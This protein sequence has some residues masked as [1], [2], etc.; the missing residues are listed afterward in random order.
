MKGPFLC[1]LGVFL[2]SAFLGVPSLCAQGAPSP[3]QPAP[4]AVS[5]AA[6]PKQSATPPVDLSPLAQGQQLYRVGKFEAASEQYN[7]II[8]QGVDAGPAYAGLARV[9]LKQRKIGEAHAAAQKAV[10]L[11]PQLPTAHVALAE[12]YFRQGRFP[13]TEHELLPL[14]QSKSPDPRAL[15]LLS[16]VYRA[17]SYYARAKMLVDNAHSLDPADPDIRRQWMATL[18]PQ[19]RLK[20]LEAYLSGKTNDNEKE[21]E[22]L[23]REI[24]DLKDLIGQPSRGCHLTTKIASTQSKLEGLMRDEKHLRGYGLKVVVNGVTSKLLLDTGAGGILITKQIA[25]KAGV[26]RVVETEFGGIGNEKAAAGY[27]G[28]ADSIKIGELEFQNCY[29]DVVEKS[30]RAGGDGLIGADVF[31]DFLI[32]LNLVD[33]KFSLSPLPPLPGEQ[34]K[35]ATLES[36]GSEDSRF[37]DRHIAPEMKSYT[38]V[39]RFGHDLLIQTHLNEGPPKLF[40]IDTGAFDN[41]ISP[42]AARE[43]TKVHS[44]ASFRISGINGEVKN[45]M[46]AD[47]V[48]LQFAHLKQT[49]HDIFSID[50]SDISDSAGTEVSGILGFAMLYL[51]DI[52]IDYRDGLVDMSFDPKRWQ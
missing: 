4:P 5:P 11:A 30:S 47:D 39:Y 1:T 14:M 41:Q 7:S 18:S 2:A 50:L 10:E 21:R 13:E 28:Y 38:P 25:D 46:R 20:A 9:Y 43:V 45:V 24:Q 3:S 44:D 35:E 49:R 16:R 31:S 51:I 37:H 32:D 15:L 52:K 8:K 17:A 27:I 36:R 26:K 29:V 48:T 12:V 42:E 23:K 34:P 19:E 40:L 6:S 22:D 33:A